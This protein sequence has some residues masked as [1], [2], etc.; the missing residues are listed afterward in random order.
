VVE[1]SRPTTNQQRSTRSLTEIA[2]VVLTV[3]VVMAALTYPPRPRAACVTI[4]HR[5]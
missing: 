3:F 1:A 2:L 4:G 5:R